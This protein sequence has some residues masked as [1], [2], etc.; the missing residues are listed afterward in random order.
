MRR[1][2]RSNR[3][4]R[5]KSTAAIVALTLA[6]GGAGIGLVVMPQASAITPPVSFTAD[7]LPTWQTNG[8]VWAMAS[9][10]DKVFV[11]GTFSS[12]RPPEGASGSERSAV[13][14]A[15]FDA[16]TGAPTSCKLSFTVRSGSATVRALALSPDKKTLYAGGYFGAVNG[17]QV[18]SLAAVD[19]ASC[20]PKAA[21]RPGFPATVRALAVNSGTVYAAGDFHQVSGQKRE[22]FAAL[23]AATGALRS[24]RADADEPGR[25]LEFTPDGKKL[26]LGGEFFTVNGKDSHALAVVDATT[27]AVAKSFPDNFI[28]LNSA[29][30]GIA[31]DDTGFYTANEGTGRGSFDG[32]I[33]FDLDDYGQR[34][35]DFCFGATQAVLAYEKVLY[36]ASHAHD[37]AGSGE[38]PDGRRHHLLAQRV[39]SPGKIG[40]APDTNDGMGEQVGPRV[41]SVAAKGTTKYLWVGG[42]FTKVNG[43]DQVGLT[44]FASTGDVG[45]PTT[46]LISAEGIKPDAVQVR[47]RTSLDLDDSRLTYRIYRNGSTKSIATVKANSLFFLRRQASWTDTTVEAGKKYTYRVRAVDAAGN[48]S[49]LSRIAS[50][51]VPTSEGAYQ[52][53]VR[54]DGARLY[55][56]YDDEVV[57]FVADSSVS[58]NTSGLHA[59]GPSLRQSPDA[60]RGSG[61]AIGFNGRDEQVYSDHRTTV[62]RSY[63]LET[64]FKTTTELGG[65]LIGFGNNTTRKSSKYDKQLYMTD[66]GRLVFGADDGSKRTVS[67]PS[68]TSYNDGKWHHVVAAQGSSSG[69]ALYVDGKKV[70]SRSVTKH[71]DIAGFWHVGGDNL[72]GWPM[73]PTSDFFAGQIDETA[74]YSKALTANQVARHYRL[75]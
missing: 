55:W 58:G 67:S 35:R 51:T 71:R 8:I 44:R 48:S 23:N 33:A 57:P 42:E 41:L 45:A 43:S 31:T 11:G 15:V 14:F 10:G 61:T 27:G 34:W 74:V 47:W 5:S 73:R 21:F 22:R 40:W 16:A 32:R 19:V 53:Q 56:R 46:P 60:V 4:R 6:G 28:P 75:R 69:M 30:K 18:S 37:C 59:G 63:T 64:W 38:Y 62:S 24:F 72:Y 50:V 52:K 1:S 54:A 26:I 25:A 49:A 36:S 2:R 17:Q 65:K 66:S 39:T 68:G 20:T 13:N 7:A 29:V 9:A 70:A 3:S 12:V